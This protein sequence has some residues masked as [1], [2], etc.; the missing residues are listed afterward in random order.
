MV[1]MFLFRARKTC[2]ETALC[3]NEPVATVPGSVVLRD[4]YLNESIF[5]EQIM[6][7][8]GK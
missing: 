6:L 2:K 1:L 7:L 5:F 8:H 4:F 3:D